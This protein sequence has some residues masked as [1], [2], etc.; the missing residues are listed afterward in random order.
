M[1][2]GSQL[3]LTDRK[4][5][6]LDVY[7]QAVMQKSEELARMGRPV[8]VVYL[9][10]IENLRIFKS[11]EYMREKY[12]GNFTYKILPMTSTNQ[13]IEFEFII[14]ENTSLDRLPFVI[15]FFADIKLFVTADVFIGSHSSIYIM[16]A[17]LRAANYF[18]RPPS[19]TCYISNN[20]E[21]FCEGE[22]GKSSVGVPIWGN[23]FCGGLKGGVPY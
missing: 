15:E 5:Q 1:R 14:R 3:D 18:E 7:M 21:L 8:K 9:T 23:L 2:A 19:H 4:L 6:P 10:S 17:A 16:S 13:S 20:K 12:G 11:E 22:Y